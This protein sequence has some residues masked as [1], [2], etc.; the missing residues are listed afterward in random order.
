MFFY[1]N[2]LRGRIFYVFVMFSLSFLISYFYKE[3]LFYF[4]VKPIFGLT[5]NTIISY[6]IY[7]NITEVFLMY[8]KTPLFLSLYL[9]FFYLVYQF[10]KFFVPGFYNSEQNL[11]SFLCCWSFLVRIF[12]DILVY[13]FLLPKTWFFFSGYT[14]SKNNDL[15]PLFFEAKLEDYIFFICQLFLTVS[16][17]LQ[18]FVLL[19]FFIF[20][21]A[22][23]DLKFIK[24]F[25]SFFY[26]FTFFF[27]CI[28]T[29]PDVLSQFAL[30]LPILAFY[31]FLVLNFLFRRNIIK[32]AFL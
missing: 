3:A 15:I 11:I 10:W 5:N 12:T 30:A 27:A 4:L 8:L 21:Y 24:N 22:K 23:I 9:Q 18:I 17:M 2:E 13:F 29:P 16:S 20:K 14:F 28:A 6:F 7:T 26:L 25:R 32:V 31:E 1:F 19:L